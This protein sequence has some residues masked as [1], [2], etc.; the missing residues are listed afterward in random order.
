MTL[1]PRPKDYFFRVR[2]RKPR[3]MP[4]LVL[5]H[6]DSILE[7]FKY[8]ASRNL[9]GRTRAYT[10]AKAARLMFL[11][12]LYRRSSKQVRVACWKCD[13]E[14]TVN[15]SSVLYYDNTKCGRCYL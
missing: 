1:L 7:R 4:P 6:R 8:L 5:L 13:G 9:A 14:H 10:I 15:Y 3:A 2:R 12:W 11:Y